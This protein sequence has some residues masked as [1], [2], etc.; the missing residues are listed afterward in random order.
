MSSNAERAGGLILVA[1]SVSIAIRN[2]PI[3]VALF[4]A[5]LMA[6]SL[7]RRA[8]PSPAVA[9]AA[10]CIC[11]YAPSVI[12]MILIAAALRDFGLHLPRSDFGMYYAAALQLRTD[13]G[14]LYDL[15]AQNQ[16]LNFVTG[17]L[18]N[19]YLSFPYPPFVAAIFV[20]LTW[21]PF[22]SAYWTMAGLNIALA[23]GIVFLLCRSLFSRRSQV[24]AL[25]LTA[26]VM[27]PLYVNVVLGQTAFIGVALYSLFILDMLQKKSARAGLWVA[28][29][30]YK[31][32]LMPV[33]FLLLL[34]RRAWKAI[35]VVVSVA[36]ALA[37]LSLSIVGTAG[38]RANLRV[39]TMMTDESLIPRMQSLRGLTHFLGMP[40]WVFWV[41]GAAIAGTLLAVERRGG[42][43]KWVLAAAVLATL[44]ISPY[45]QMYDVSLALPAIALAISAM[46]RVSDW[47][48][49]AFMLLALV[50]S[51]AGIV[52][53]VAQR[54]VPAVPV[55]T[56]VAFCY[57]LCRAVADKAVAPQDGGIRRPPSDARAAPMNNDSYQTP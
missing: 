22:R 9:R 36:L 55:T 20:P 37:L 41:L 6:L 53:L 7:S 13:P 23:A 38:M 8:H 51:F 50:P 35:F 5:G 33:P 19:H 18:Q 45:I 34:L 43:P 25:A 28:L 10:T 32:V 21:L 30:S 11:T 54:N 48:R 17:G 39:M 3:G 15:T 2:A 49:T 1:L 16:M 31:I 56:L 4:L 12:L 46:S 52:G 44:L 29:L 47:Q 27:F 42:D 40:G 26:S 24:L 57:C 14:R